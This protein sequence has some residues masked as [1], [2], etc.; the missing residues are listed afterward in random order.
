MRPAS[1][2]GFLPV[3]IKFPSLRLRLRSFRLTAM[4]GCLREQQF[5]PIER[6]KPH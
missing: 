5:D 1:D 4:I 2:A 6:P 3:A